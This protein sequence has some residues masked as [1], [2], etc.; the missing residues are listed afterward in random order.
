MRSPF[1]WL[2]FST[3]TLFSISLCSV[4]VDPVAGSPEQNSVKPVSPFGKWIRSHHSTEK[5]EG[6]EFVI[7]RCP[8][9]AR[10]IKVEFM[11]VPFSGGR[12]M[13]HTLNSLFKEPRGG[14]SQG[15]NVVV[16]TISEFSPFLHFAGKGYRS[17][18][19]HKCHPSNNSC[20][21]D[22][23]FWDENKLTCHLWVYLSREPV[24]RVTECI[25]AS[26]LLQNP[27]MML[28]SSAPVC[29]RA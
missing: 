18:D 22:E 28:S 16:F 14:R 8:L 25:H 19:P 1:A 9:E 17:K 5:D 29:N 7:R 2:L 20:F 27:C 24:N 3:A 21:S 10:T 13:F 4:S 15:H 6:E 11:H 26:I 23:Y 12:T